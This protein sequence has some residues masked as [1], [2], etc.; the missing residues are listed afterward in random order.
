[1]NNGTFCSKWETM[2]ILLSQSWDRSAVALTQGTQK[3]SAQGQATPCD[4]S[5]GEEQWVMFSSK[6]SWSHAEVELVRTYA[7]SKKV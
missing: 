7:A 3:S 1:M 5:L 2:D 4:L 6:T